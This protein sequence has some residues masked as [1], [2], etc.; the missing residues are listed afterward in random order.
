[1]ECRGKKLPVLSEIGSPSASTPPKPQTRV[2]IGKPGWIEAQ[3]GLKGEVKNVVNC[4]LRVRFEEILWVQEKRL[5][6]GCSR[7]TSALTVAPVLL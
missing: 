5:L 3:E 4:S 7:V 2:N 1:L 6:N